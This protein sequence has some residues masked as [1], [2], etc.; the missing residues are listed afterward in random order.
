MVENRKGW[1]GRT[2]MLSGAKAAQHGAEPASVGERGC[3]LAGA[4]SARSTGP[5]ST[6]QCRWQRVKG[7]VGGAGAQCR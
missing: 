1:G 5:P 4:G 6:G 7:G 2:Q 3:G